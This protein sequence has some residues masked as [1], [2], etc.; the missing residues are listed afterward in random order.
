LRAS[1]EKASAQIKRT[2]AW[3]NLGRLSRKFIAWASEYDS[4]HLSGRSRKRHEAWLARLPCPVI[5]LEN[6]QDVDRLIEAALRAVQY[7]QPSRR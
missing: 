6:A 3:R 7:L 4:G 5:R 1:W 2:I